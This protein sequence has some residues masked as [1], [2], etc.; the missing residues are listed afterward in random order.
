MR[1]SLSR[2]CHTK[3]FPIPPCPWQLHERSALKQ[4]SRPP[5]EPAHVIAYTSVLSYK[6][7]LSAAPV[8]SADPEEIDAGGQRLRRNKEPALPGDVYPKLSALGIKGGASHC[9][10]V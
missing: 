1:L 10:E 9:P 3:K 5:K 8:F 4:K 2:L 6:N 7:P